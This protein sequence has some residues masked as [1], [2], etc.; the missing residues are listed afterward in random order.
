LLLGIFACE[1][2]TSHPGLYPF[3]G[4]HS[5]RHVSRQIG[6]NGAN[7]AARLGMSNSGEL[8]RLAVR[9][10]AGHE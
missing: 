9:R 2:P 10:S 8:V 5:D 6:G 3:D 7:Q 1:M 4:M